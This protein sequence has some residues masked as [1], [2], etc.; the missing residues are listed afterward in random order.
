M[1]KITVIISGVSHVETDAY[2]NKEDAIAHLIDD[3]GCAKIEK[4]DVY[5]N[6]ELVFLLKELEVK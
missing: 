6:N 3:L 1:S 5:A 2:F 4:H